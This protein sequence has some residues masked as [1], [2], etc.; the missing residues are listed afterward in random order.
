[1]LTHISNNHNIEMYS[2]I[3][4]RVNSTYSSLMLFEIWRNL[5]LKKLIFKWYRKYLHHKNNS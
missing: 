2:K 3:N 4:K 1:M 5:F